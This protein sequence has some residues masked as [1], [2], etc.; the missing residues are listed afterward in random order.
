MR[1]VDTDMSGAVDFYEF[2]S[3]VVQHSARPTDS[4]NGL[5]DIFRLLDRDERGMILAEE[6]RFLLV[7]LRCGCGAASGSPVK[8]T[9]RPE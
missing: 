7:K 1:N 4:R 5:R 6:V 9:C 2:L 8:Q 3:F